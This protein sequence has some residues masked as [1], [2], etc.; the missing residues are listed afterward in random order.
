MTQLD[1]NPRPPEGRDEE[2]NPWPQW[3]RIHRKLA[4]AR[5]GRGRVLGA[6]GGRLPRPGRT[7]PSGPWSPRRCRS[8]G[9]TGAGCSGRCR[10]AGQEVPCELVLVAAGFVGTERG[11]LLDRLGVEVD[12]D[13][14]TAAAARWLGDLRAGRLRLRRRH[15]RGQPGG[16]GDRR[17][18]G[19][20][21]R[22]RHGA[23]RPD[24]AAGPG[25]PRHPPPVEARA[26]RSAG[27]GTPGR[28]LPPG[29]PA[30]RGFLSDPADL[31][32]PCGTSW[33]PGRRAAA[34]SV[35]STTAASR[36]G[37]P[38]R[39]TSLAA[40]VAAR[41][42]DSPRWVWPATEDVYPELLAAGVRVGR[43]H[44]LELTEALLLGVGRPVG[45][46][47]GARRPPGPGWPACRCP[48]TRRRARPARPPSR[49]CSRPTPAALPGG[50]PRWTRRSPCTPTSCG[51]IAAAT[52]RRRT[53]C[54]CWWPPSRRARWWPPR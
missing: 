40:A 32:A 46:A 21:G 20:R 52:R 22:G 8:S 10:T 48:P 25:S 23:E 2:L 53:G 27:L 16:L 15:P 5:G 30:R 29:A 31:M 49:R 24:R 54:G 44:D 4:G 19:L 36:S 51:R 18:P 35:R 34:R 28:L 17:G 26:R 13:R 42:R 50:R 45:R 39:S 7:G 43:C 33:W 9:W 41:E 38:R 3:P 14:G 6:G 47:A 11:S 12:P 37:R 1:H